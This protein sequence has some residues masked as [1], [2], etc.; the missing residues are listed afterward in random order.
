MASSE[1]IKSTVLLLGDLV[2]ELA[3]VLHEVTK[4]AG[5]RDLEERVHNAL[6]RA[7]ETLELEL[8]FDQ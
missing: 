3:V 1:S 6:L 7:T 2:A 8:Q 5:R 4:I